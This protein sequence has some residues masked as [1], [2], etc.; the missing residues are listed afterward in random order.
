MTSRYALMNQTNG[1][2][3]PMLK[4]QPTVGQNPAGR[5]GTS[6]TCLRSCSASTAIQLLPRLVDQLD[7]LGVE[8]GEIRLCCMRQGP[9]HEQLARTQL[10]EAVA[11]DCAQAPFR[12]VAHHGIADGLRYDETHASGVGVIG[13][14]QAVRHEMG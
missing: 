14:S 1:I 2:L 5:R 7:D 9:Q 13:V 11:H 10:T 6:E 12:A 8:D 4:I 3:G